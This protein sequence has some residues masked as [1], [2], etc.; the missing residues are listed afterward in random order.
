[1]SDHI[2]LDN[3][4]RGRR[5]IQTVCDLR[6]G[7]LSGCR[8][9]DLGCAHGQFALEF[10]RRGAIAL[11]IEGRASWVQIANSSKESSSINTAKFVQDDVRNLSIAKYGTFDVVL[12]LGL[13]Y[14]LD[15]K[16]VFD[17]MA[18]I[19]DV[20][21]DFA[22]IDT[23]VASRPESS[24][25]W[26]GHK[27]WGSV[28]REHEAMATPDAKMATLGASLDDEY[29]F[30]MTRSSLFNA[31]RHV[32][33][34]SLLECRNPLDNM[35]AFGEFKM[36]A[37]VVTLVAMKGQPAGPFFGMTPDR[38]TEEDWPENSSEYFLKRPWSC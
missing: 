13:L 36:H 28:Y 29:S 30:W 2:P 12:C 14:H 25:E 20:C 38:Q 6:R 11:G 23:Q 32:G 34:T 5:F 17:F 7:T 4:P 15:A 3:T 21:T 22:V 37:D 18:N 10:A 27:Y 33:F 35:Y 26:H 9:L 24:V 8:L 16:D 31:L 19:F 1:M